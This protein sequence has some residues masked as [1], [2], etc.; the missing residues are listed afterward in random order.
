[1]FPDP[2]EPGEQGCGD[3]RLIFFSINAKMAVGD[4][5]RLQIHLS[6]GIWSFFTNNDEFTA[7]ER[8]YYLTGRNSDGAVAWVN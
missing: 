5:A 6:I 7:L 1:M 3:K 4:P 8:T 2:A